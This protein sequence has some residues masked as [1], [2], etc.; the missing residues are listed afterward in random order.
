MDNLPS[1]PT[2]RCLWVLVCLSLVACTGEMSMMDGD[3]GTDSAMGSDSTVGPDSAM[4]SDSAVP[5]GSVA[6]SA[7]DSSPPRDAAPRPDAAPPPMAG[8][9]PVTVTADQGSASDLLV[10]VA[11]P[12]PQGALHDAALLRLLELDGSERASAVDV[13]AL[14]PVDSS[15]RSALMVFR[16]TLSRDASES[17]ELEYGAPRESTLADAVVAHP[18]GAAVALLDTGWLAASRVSGPLVPA[19]QNTRFGDFDAEVTRRLGTMDPDFQS[20]GVSCGSTSSHR[21]YYDSPHTLWL[22]Y[23][24]AATAANYR[25]ARVEATWYRANELEWH[26]GRDMAVQICE[27]D[28]WTSSDKIGWSVIRRMTS[29]GMLDDYLITGDPAARE[30]VVAMGEAFVRSL[31]AQR[32]GRENSLLVTERNLAWTLMGVAAYYAL[33]PTAAVRAALDSLVAEAEDWQAAGTSGAFE[34]D[35]VRPDPSE[36]SDGPAG[37]SPFMTSLLID[38]L[39]DAYAVTNDARIPAIVVRSAE[40]YRDSAVTSSGDA[41][42]YLWGCSSDDY[43]DTSSELN[44]LIVHVF[45]AAYEVSGDDAWLDVGDGF[46]DAG[47]SAIFVRRP[48]QWNQ[49]VRGFARYIG[50]RAGGRTP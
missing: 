31:G 36:C 3:G 14:W 46:A 18:D 6:D 33:E 38:G 22:H 5:D 26:E 48:K 27:A 16:T 49:T 20:Y 40:W 47:L 45:G 32:G 30:A 17:L 37:A 12:F 28:D 44:N 13:L 11:V 21:T 29:G 25:R 9:I 23:L 43:D 15:I 10:S 19:A 4:G 8:R 39:M 42:E 41:F 35:I 1:S 50:Y 7:T 2:R 24:R 34:H